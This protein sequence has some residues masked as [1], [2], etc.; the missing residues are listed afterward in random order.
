MDDYENLD[1]YNGD[2]VHDMWVDSD[3]NENI[4]ELQYNIEDETDL[5]NFI[6]NLN[7]WD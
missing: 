1:T 4:G 5:D 7:D 2:S 6:D 3:Y